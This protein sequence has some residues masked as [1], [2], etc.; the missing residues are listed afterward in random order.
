MVK[1]IRICMFCEIHILTFWIYTYFAD[2]CT[3][4]GQSI[5]FMEH[6]TKLYSC[7]FWKGLQ[8]TPPLDYLNLKSLHFWSKHIQVCKGWCRH[9]VAGW[10]FGCGT[11]WHKV[12][13]CGTRWLVS[14]SLSSSSDSHVGRRPNLVTSQRLTWDKTLGDIRYRGHAGHVPSPFLLAGDMW[15]RGRAESE[16][17]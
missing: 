1:F 10:H 6:E 2:T 8:L 17:P 14:G 3:Q 4:A 13:Q 7:L 16:P 11:R 15:Y 5:C 9:P 12:A